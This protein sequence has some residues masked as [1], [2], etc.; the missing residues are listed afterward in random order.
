MA[1]ETNQQRRNPLRNLIEAVKILI[2]KTHPHPHPLCPENGVPP[3]ASKKTT[4]PRC[5]NTRSQKKRRVKRAK[6]ANTLEGEG[7]VAIEVG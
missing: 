4:N 7:G 6:R 1:D 2:I 5:P 3:S